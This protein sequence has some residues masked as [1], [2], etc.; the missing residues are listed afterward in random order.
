MLVTKIKGRIRFIKIYLTQ[1]S[2]AWACLGGL[3]GQALGGWDDFLICLVVFVVCDYL[4]GILAAIT[5]GLSSAR[6]FRGILEKML[7]F[8]LVALGH[9]LATAL[10][11]GS[12][13]PL[14]SAM[15]FFYLSNEGLSIIENL[16]ALGVPIPNRLKQVVA[17]LGEEGE[18]GK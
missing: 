13:A 9:L 16:G 12:G 1:V 8:L 7:I 3:L 2:L 4:T 14:R 18:N 15:I 17:E 6:G 10:L 11:G 5:G